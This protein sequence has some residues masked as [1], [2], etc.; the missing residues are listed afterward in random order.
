MNDVSLTFIFSLISI[1]WIILFTFNPCI[2]KV[3]KEWEFYPSK[4]ADPDP[5]KCLIFSS[6]F[7][8][9]IFIIIYFLKRNKIIT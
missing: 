8:L 3:K 5:L 9:I 7:S 6:L 2:V 4:Q 1:V